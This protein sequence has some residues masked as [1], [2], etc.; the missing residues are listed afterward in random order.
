MPT[1]LRMCGLSVPSSVE[2]IGLPL[3]ASDRRRDWVYSEY[4]AGEPDF[5]WEEARRLGPAQRLGDYSLKSKEEVQGLAKREHGGHLRMART[6]NHKLIADSNGDIEFYDLAKDP[7]E[8]ENVHG[9]PEYR[10]IE[11]DLR[12]KL[13]RT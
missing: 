4:G 6:H 7:N 3:G 12:R 1:L 10:T 2:G 9:K 11:D 13:D 8:M 5:T